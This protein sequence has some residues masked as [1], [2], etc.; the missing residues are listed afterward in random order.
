MTTF[1]STAQATAHSEK[2][3][4]TGTLEYT[5][6]ALLT[7]FFW[8]LWG[9]F[10]VMI[11]ESVVPN[12]V[13]VQLNALGASSTVIGFI[14]GTVGSIM[15]FILNPIFSTWS[16]RH[17]GKLGRRRPFLLWATPVVTICLIMI[18]YSGRF[19]PA[20]Y[21]ALPWL[22]TFVSAQQ[23]AIAVT[24]ILVVIFTFFNLFIMTIF[25]Y[26]APDVVPE[27][28]L[29]KFIACFRIAGMLAGFAFNQWILG[30]ADKH[31]EIIYLST[32]LLYMT[33][34]LLLVWRVKEGEYPPPPKTKRAGLL[35]MASR[36]AKE[37]FSDPFY[38]LLFLV[39]AMSQ[40]LPTASRIF[41]VLY[42]TKD[43]G[44]SMADY[45]KAIAM[46]SLLSIPALIVAGIMADKFH[47]IRMAIVGNILV[48]AV[49]FC[50]FFLI[51]DHSSFYFWIILLT[52]VQMFAYGAASP[53]FARVMARHYFG[54]LCSANAVVCSLIGIPAPL[55][56]GKI[57]D[58]AG[59]NLY[60]FLW[61]AL[62]CSFGAVGYWALYRKWLQMGGDLHY[63][64]PLP[65]LEEAEDSEQD[66][67]IMAK[68]VA[69]SSIAETP[70]TPV[71]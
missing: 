14:M 53:L 36:Y 11:M 69:K 30:Y 71:Q 41:L 33:A 58:V 55:I 26:L 17:R 68:V 40:A 13:P 24:G 6:A 2:P 39:T 37:S 23:F 46:G 65:P 54:Q 64:A 44:L 48:A 42:A 32:G 66:N 1:S 67:N 28:V 47:P 27:R 5:R 8:L 45:G 15:N 19:T 7:M 51:H 63:E 35:R 62:F 60:L 4:R 56:V 43:L 70:S 34:F 61:S 25:F 52:V 50:C 57:I 59:S 31:P 10:C 9:D 49:N 20:L 3:Y 18:G 38:R 12:L 29:G 16:D 22:H 21:A